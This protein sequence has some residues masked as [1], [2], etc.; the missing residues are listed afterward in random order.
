MVR[1]DN[2]YYIINGAINGWYLVA[3]ILPTISDFIIII[4]YGI[5]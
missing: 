1:I 3:L 4:N 2:V 5:L